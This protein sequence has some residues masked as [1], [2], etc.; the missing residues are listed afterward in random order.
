[1]NAR[2]L[3]AAIAL[4][5]CAAAMAQPWPAR[6]VRI[7]VGYPAGGST[8]LMARLVA[9]KLGPALGQPVL[10]ENK[11]GATGQIASAH[12]AKAEADGY[13]LLFTNAGPGAVTYGLQ[14][15]PA[16]HPVKD[17][18]P[19]ATV[20]SMPLVLAVPGTS[21]HRTVADL[22]GQGRAQPGK[23]N[24][25]STGIGSLGHIAT[26]LFNSKAGIQSKHVPYKGGAQ[27]AP[28]VISGEVDY[29]FSVPSD[30][31]PYVAAGKMKA[32]GIS[33]ARRSP[34]APDV[35]TMAEAGVPGFEVEVWYGLLAPK[36]TPRPVVERL[37][38]EMNA[39][40]QLPDVRER[41]A[42]LAAVPLQLTSEEFGGMIARDLERWVPFIRSAG[43]TAE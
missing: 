18:A 1:M 13:T 34:L 28:A 4:G 15:T 21:P 35:P 36:N 26:E 8:D 29:M 12:V 38:R 37:H 11:P 5:F 7:V 27:T 39:I 40:A 30:I 32:L 33:A 16:Y 19:I 20:A 42:S 6:P 43:I 31:L 10:V 2:N 22:V 3:L 41:I 14:K 25:A 23:L 24:F 9:Q 17:F